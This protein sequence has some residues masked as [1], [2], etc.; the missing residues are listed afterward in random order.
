MT[1]AA[2]PVGQIID[3]IAESILDF[4]LASRRRLTGDWTIARLLAEKIYDEVWERDPSD[5]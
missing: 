1:P 2:D 3:E 4:R 5:E